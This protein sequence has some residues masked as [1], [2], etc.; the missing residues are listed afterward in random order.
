MSAVR[1]G[2]AFAY[3]MPFA[4]RRVGVD[5]ARRDRRIVLLE[6]RARSSRS[7]GA[8][9]DSVMK[10]SVLPHQTITSA[11]EVVVR[12]E[13]PDVGDDLLGEV[14]LVLALL[15]VRAV[16][17]L[18]VVLVEHRRP[19][20]DLLEL[21]PHLV[22][23][24][25][26]EHAGRLAPRCSSRPRRCPSRRTRDRR[27]GERHDVVD[28]RRAAFGPL[29]EP[30]GAH[31]RQRSDRLGESLAD[32]EHAGDGGR[33]DGAEADQQDAEFAARRSDFNRSRHKRELYHRAPA[34][35]AHRPV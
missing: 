28:L 27:A 23:Q 22:E 17:P 25:L 21:G 32:G 26:L 5:H 15:D 14:A 24:R 2:A 4:D 8:P 18:H 19:R 1:F 16:E 30:D 35:C 6:R 13:L 11:I 10:T 34:R 3:G 31:L 12:L 33:A 29:A 20:A 9:G 7:T